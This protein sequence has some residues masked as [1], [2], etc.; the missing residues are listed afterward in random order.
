MKNYYVE[1]D[2]QTVALGKLSLSILKVQEKV[3]TLKNL[4]CKCNNS[5]YEFQKE[6]DEYII[7]LNKLTLEKEILQNEIKKHFDKKL[8]DAFK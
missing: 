2:D 4:K 3:D 5:I 6:L 7:Q 1:I 8:V